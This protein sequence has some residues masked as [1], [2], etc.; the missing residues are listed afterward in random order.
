MDSSTFESAYLDPKVNYLP[1]I[2]PQADTYDSFS[3]VETCPSLSSSF[4]SVD[5]QLAFEA[6]AGFRLNST[7]PDDFSVSSISLPS[8]ITPL[9]YVSMHNQYNTE[10]WMKP[11]PQEVWHR[12]IIDSENLWFTA[13][14]PSMANCVMNTFSTQT[15]AAQFQ[16]GYFSLNRPKSAADPPLSRAVFPNSFIGQSPVKL[17]EPM[18][19]SQQTLLPQP[20]TV[21]PSATF[22]ST[23][24][25]SPVKPMTPFKHHR[26]SSFSFASSP[27]TSVPS[28][29]LASQWDDEEIKHESDLGVLSYS[30]PVKLKMPM[31]SLT[32]M[33]IKKEE[34]PLKK[35]S[36]CRSGI[37][38]EAVIPQNEF[39]CTYPGC[40][41][42]EGRPKRFKRQEHKKR[43]EKTVH[44]IKDHD[45]HY[46]WVVTGNKVCGKDFSRRD[47]LKSHLKKTH[48]RRSNNQRNS[49]VAT[50]DEGSVYYD[51]EWK[52]PLT[53]EG[54]PV[55][56]PRWP[57]LH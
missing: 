44:N 30:E 49:Y 7:S 46:C 12:Q 25:S 5:T 37:D 17:E 11:E 47:N 29:V 3:Q 42:K 57:G 41:D 36:S 56:H 45:K 48:G 6:D 43:H 39:A 9:E 10:S 19:W 24:V 14:D 2:E 53:S 22:Q 32:S 35:S 52:G 34:S 54:L 23:L 38:C 51:E 16:P 18:Q 15:P 40:R 26:N 8:P 50:L 20:Q 31:R 4:L 1:N 28:S 55:G 33:P 13:D 27:L 21:E